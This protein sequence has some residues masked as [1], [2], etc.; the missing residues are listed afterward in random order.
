MYH[1][2]NFDITSVLIHI[3][4]LVV[5][6][7]WKEQFHDLFSPSNHLIRVHVNYNCIHYLVFYLIRTTNTKKLYYHNRL[8]EGIR[9]I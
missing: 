9:L 2:H 3:N 1:C 8:Y 7:C 6:K 5:T 4:P